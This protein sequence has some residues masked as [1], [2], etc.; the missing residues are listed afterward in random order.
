MNTRA[1]WPLIAAALVALSGCTTS[2]MTGRS[3]FLMVSEQAAMSGSEVARCGEEILRAGDRGGEDRQKLRGW[4]A[5]YVRW[6]RYTRDRRVGGRGQMNP[7][8]R[9]EICRV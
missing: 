7:V 2:S 6:L 8:H 4:V 9:A 3:Q 1:V 5:R